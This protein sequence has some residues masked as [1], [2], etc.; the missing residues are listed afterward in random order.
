MPIPF[1]ELTDEEVIE[2]RTWARK[3]YEPNSEIKGVWHPV[4]QEECV[5]MNKGEP[6]IVNGI[7]MARQ[8]CI[9]YDE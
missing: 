6:F 3:S 4:I 5:A 2:F 9:N 8:E 1:R 7:D